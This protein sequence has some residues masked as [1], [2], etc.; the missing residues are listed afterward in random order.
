LDVLPASESV[1]LVYQ[2]GFS[3]SFLFF[4]IQ[5]DSGRNFT[6]Y[7]LS[8]YKHPP[9]YVSDNVKHFLQFEKDWLFETWNYNKNF[10]VLTV[11]VSFIALG[12]AFWKRSLWMGLEVVVLM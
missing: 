5:T 12:L 11:P 6:D 1:E 4:R 8:I 10:L 3:D 2:A 7:F 9:E